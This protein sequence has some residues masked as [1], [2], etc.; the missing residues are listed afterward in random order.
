MRFCFIHMFVIYY[1]SV[2]E[3][4]LYL[5]AEFDEILLNNSEVIRLWQTEE[6]TD[7]QKQTQ[8]KL[9]TRFHRSITINGQLSRCK[10]NFEDIF[11][12]II[13]RKLF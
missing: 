9:R 10:D 2:S 5:I 13:F 12:T 8:V 4:Q 1:I 6:Q 3:L 7:R 11:L